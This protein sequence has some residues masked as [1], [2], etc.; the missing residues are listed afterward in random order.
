MKTYPSRAHARVGVL[1]NTMAAEK[2]ADLDKLFSFLSDSTGGGGD[3]GTGGG[4]KD[5]LDFVE[6]IN[7]DLDEMIGGDVGGGAKVA[8]EKK[9][10]GAAKNKKSA[11]KQAPPA[12][13]KPEGSQAD[14]AKGKSKFKWKK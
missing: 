13:V 5:E 9:Q 3:A 2:G 14:K 7:E 1:H 4:G 8:S 11:G 6:S 10:A 12:T